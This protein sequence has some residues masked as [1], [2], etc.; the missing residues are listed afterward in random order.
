MENQTKQNRIKSID[1]IRGLA[2]LGLIP[3]NI[4][5]FSMPMAAYLNPDAFFGDQLTSYISYFFTI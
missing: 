1:V 3:M 4:I 2:I 5:I